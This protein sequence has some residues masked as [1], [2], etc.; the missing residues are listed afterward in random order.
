[1]VL[2]D[3]QTVLAFF[4]TELLSWVACRPRETHS[5]TCWLVNLNDVS[6]QNVTPP[7]SS[8]AAA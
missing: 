4:L 8:Y 5:P 3:Q 7:T 6:S 2:N 1:M